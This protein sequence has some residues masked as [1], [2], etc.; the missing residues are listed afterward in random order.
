MFAALTTSSIAASSATLYL[1]KPS[2]RSADR[3]TS[4]VHTF[5]LLVRWHLVRWM[6]FNRHHARTPAGTQPLP[7]R[8]GFAIWITAL[9]AVPDQTSGNS[10]PRAPGHSIGL[11]TSVRVIVV[12]HRHDQVTLWV[13]PYTSRWTHNYGRTGFFND[14]RPMEHVP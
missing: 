3:F 2:P 11:C 6:L 14:R 8:K 7:S 12:H 5:H 10:D 1:P 4:I 9:H 13:H